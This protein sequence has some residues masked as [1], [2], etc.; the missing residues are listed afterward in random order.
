M[1]LI[2]FKSI[3][4]KWFWFYFKSNFW[5][6]WLKMI[7]NYE[8]ILWWEFSIIS[9]KNSANSYKCTYLFAL[10]KTNFFTVQK[11]IIKRCKMSSK[12][13]TNVKLRKWLFRLM[14]EIDCN[15]F[16]HDF[17]FNHFFQKWFWFD[18]N[19]N[20]RD[21]FDLIFSAKSCISE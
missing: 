8:I 2:L 16:F 1:I 15:Q 21:D 12:C 10:A 17:D 13:L 14:I 3:S 20:F 19:H 18:L 7:A 9:K 4:M 11:S 6:F 5:W